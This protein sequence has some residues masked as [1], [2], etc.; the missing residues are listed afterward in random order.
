MNLISFRQ[1]TLLHY[2]NVES[3]GVQAAFNKT[4]VPA[5]MPGGES[6]TITASE[7]SFHSIIA[8][9]E[10]LLP[11]SAASGQSAESQA[12]LLTAKN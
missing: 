5:I 8:I 2:N 1:I 11:E 4:T 9:Q 3:D 7:T 12:E 10:T 6:R